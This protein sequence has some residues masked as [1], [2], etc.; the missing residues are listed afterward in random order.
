MR[1]PSAQA[2]GRRSQAEASRRNPAAAPRARS[3]SGTRSCLRSPSERSSSR[4]PTPRSGGS[5]AGTVTG[6]SLGSNTRS[7]THARRSRWPSAS[8]RSRI[9]PARTSAGADTTR[10]VGRTKPIHSRCARISGSSLELAISSSPARDRRAQPARRAL[11]APRRTPECAAARARDHGRTA[12]GGLRQE[13]MSD[14][15]WRFSSSPKSRVSCSNAP[16]FLASSSRTR[17]RCRSRVSRRSFSSRA[18][19]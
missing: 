2:R 1:H 4:G 5:R 14:S 15:S 3:G 9:A 8:R 6:P 16:S 11:R 13:R 12:R 19:R 7:A 10:P 18:P 17:S